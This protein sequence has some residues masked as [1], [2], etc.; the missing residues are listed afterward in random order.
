MTTTKE[1]EDAVIHNIMAICEDYHREKRTF[2]S[3]KN[4][5]IRNLEAYNDFISSKK[6][7]VLL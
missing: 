2:I 6:M 3:T 1:V 7:E 4:T 5:I